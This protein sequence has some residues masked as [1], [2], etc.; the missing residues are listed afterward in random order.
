MV[1]T[2]VSREDILIGI[3]G[4]GSSGALGDGMTVEYHGCHGTVGGA[5]I[6]GSIIT[7]TDLQLFHVIVEGEINGDGAHFAIGEFDLGKIALFAVERREKVVVVNVLSVFLNV[8]VK[9]NTAKEAHHGSRFQKIVRDVDHHAVGIGFEAY[10]AA[11]CVAVKGINLP[12]HF[13]CNLPR[14]ATEGFSLAAGL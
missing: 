6:D 14:H 4:L 8:K 5:V 9:A 10:S 13:V 3:T 2:I 12:A 7:K 1:D 11:R